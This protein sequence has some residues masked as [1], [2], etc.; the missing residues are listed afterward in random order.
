LCAGFP[1]RDT[2]ERRVPLLGLL[3]LALLASC[4][5]SA[6]PARPEVSHRQQ[7]LLPAS[8]EDVWRAAH[9]AV[10]EARLR[11][12][13]EDEK[14]GT[15]HFW[16]RRTAGARPDV[17][18]RE[19]TRIAETEDARRRGLEV[20]S[21][22]MVEYELSLARMDDDATR[23]ELSTRIGA[24]DR[25]QAMM[26]GAFVQVIP[27]RFDVPSKGVLERDLVL[28]IGSRLFVAE[29]MLYDFGLLGRD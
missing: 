14:T 22:I 21:E 6:G 29:E 24:I 7:R 17:L 11:I 12:S 26:L 18:F 8:F 13:D 5:P 10:E 25:S 1:G 2:R 23:L 9:A 27:R 19:L 3:L 16:F 4:M 28:A 15:M 20:L